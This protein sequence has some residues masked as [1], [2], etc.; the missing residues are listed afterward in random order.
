MLHQEEL[1]GN[2]RTMRYRQISQEI[3]VSPFKLFYAIIDV[4]S[5]NGK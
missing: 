5:F 2:S 1:N 4:M 3:D